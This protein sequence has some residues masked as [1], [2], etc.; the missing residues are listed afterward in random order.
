M[1]KFLDKIFF[2][3]LLRNII[4]VLKF[5]FNFYFYFYVVLLNSNIY[6]V[7]VVLERLLSVFIIMYII[8]KGEKDL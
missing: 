8:E 6:D 3:V 4:I 1:L 7:F 2:R 5:L